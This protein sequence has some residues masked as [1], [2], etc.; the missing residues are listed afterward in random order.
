MNSMLV[1]TMGCVCVQ[2]VIFMSWIVEC[3]NGSTRVKMN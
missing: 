3:S 1:F 2:M